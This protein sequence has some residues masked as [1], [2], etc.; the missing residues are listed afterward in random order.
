MTNTLRTRIAAVLC[1]HPDLISGKCHGIEEPEL[2][3]D[4]QD[5]WAD[6]VADV[7][8]SELPEL[9]P[10]PFCG[11]SHNKCGC[12]RTAE[13]VQISER[14]MSVIESGLTLRQAHEI[15]TGCSQDNLCAECRKETI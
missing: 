2:Q 12:L 1:A 4:H 6:H 13:P 10:C 14:G 11:L 9:Q 3:F 5:K 7:L 15:K 8:I